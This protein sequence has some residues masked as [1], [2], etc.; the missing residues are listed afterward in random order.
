MKL[1]KVNLSFK[2]PLATAKGMSNIYCKL[3]GSCLTSFSPLDYMDLLQ[4]HKVEALLD[5]FCESFIL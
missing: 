1:P 4:A 2:E 5:M 3:M